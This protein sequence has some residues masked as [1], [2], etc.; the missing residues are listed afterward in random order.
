MIATATSEIEVE[1][2]KLTASERVLAFFDR[3]LL[4]G[5]KPTQREPQNQ[6]ERRPRRGIAELEI[7]NVGNQNATSRKSDNGKKIF[8]AVFIAVILAVKILVLIV[9]LSN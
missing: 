1:T 9:K 7:F 5:K 2:E 3:V 8:W 6:N 4:C